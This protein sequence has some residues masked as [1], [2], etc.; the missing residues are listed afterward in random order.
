[1]YANL[2]SHPE[3]QNKQNITVILNEGVVDLV[4]NILKKNVLLGE[5]VVAGIDTLDGLIQSK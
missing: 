5:V 2:C 3:E 1:M 4:L